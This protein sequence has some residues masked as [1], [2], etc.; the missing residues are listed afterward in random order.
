M[1]KKPLQLTV[2]A[3]AC[4]VLAT[5]AHAQSALTFDPSWSFSGF[6]TLAYTKIDTDQAEFAAPGQ[7]GGVDKSGGFSPDSKLGLQLTGK[8]NSIFSATVQLLSKKNGVGTY[9]PEVEWA[10][11]KAQALP[12]LA[13][14]VGRIGATCGCARRSKSTDRCRSATSTVPMR[15]TRSRSARP[16]SPARL[17]AA[18]PPRTT[19]T[20][21]S[22]CVALPA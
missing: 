17:L 10:F 18:P 8:V 9:K 19:T 13:V 3:A 6:G 22:T 2:L 14:R 4:T 16:P 5:S 20:R 15:S 7:F 12:E 11:A 21:A 1:K